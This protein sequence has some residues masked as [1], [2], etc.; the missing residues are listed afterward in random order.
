MAGQGGM[1]VLCVFNI[2]VSVIR[3]TGQVSNNA[4]IRLYNVTED[5][6]TFET[7]MLNNLAVQNERANENRRGEDSVDKELQK[8]F[9]EIDTHW[10]LGVLPTSLQSEHVLGRV[11]DLLKETH[12]NPL[13]VLAEI[14][15]YHT[16]GLLEDNH[17]LL[18]Y[19]RKTND[20]S[21]NMLA[22]G[23]EEERKQVVE[24]W[25]PARTGPSGRF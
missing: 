8:L 11:G 3:R 2:T 7:D 23:T 18:A 1:D 16:R 25:L 12:Q 5:K 9:Q 20:H 6:E 19:Q 17:L 14:R 24:P 10:R 21:G 13:P 15:M 4:R 22:T